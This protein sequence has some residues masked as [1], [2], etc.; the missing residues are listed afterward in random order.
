MSPRDMPVLK[1]VSRPIF[2]LV[3]QVFRP[4]RAGLGRTE[5]LR[6]MRKRL[7]AQS[8]ARA[9][10]SALACSADD[11]MAV[12]CPIFRP[13]RGVALPY[14]CSLT[15]PM[16][17]AAAQFGFRR[18]PQIAQQV[19]HRGRLQQLGRSQ[20]QPADRAQLLFELARAA[21]VERQVPGV[22][23]PR[24]QLV[25]Q[26]PAVARRRR[27]RRTGRR[28]SRAPPAPSRVASTASRAISA[29]HVRRR[30]RHVEDVM[31]VRV[32]DR[33]EVRSIAVD[34]RARQRPRSR[35]RDR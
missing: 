15:S 28:R 27:T 2:K 34:A 33:S 25:D 17:R 30:H 21:G 20:R 11:A 22:V 8:V 24:R 5:V 1:Q 35:A 3:A 29:R 13:G 16:A 18:R 10:T 19:R 6:Y 32:V 7:A 4:A 9:Q 23:R 12:R 14:R 31:P 26:Q